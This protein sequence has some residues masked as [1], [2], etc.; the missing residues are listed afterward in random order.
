M[1]KNEHFSKL[2]RF[3]MVSNMKD[4]RIKFRKRMSEEQKSEGLLTQSHW[5]QII[6][7]R[8]RTSRP[9]LPQSPGLLPL[10]GK[11]EPYFPAPILSYS[12]ELYTKQNPFPHSLPLK[13]MHTTTASPY[14]I[15]SCLNYIQ[16][17]RV[18]FS[19]LPSQ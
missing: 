19:H 12:P 8:Q 5:N 6:T 13:P 16:F 2:K 18:S 7:S 1:L 14:Q 15:L 10:Q 4:K 11:R 17:H 9:D 3:L